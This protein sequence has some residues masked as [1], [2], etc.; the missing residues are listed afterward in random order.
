MNLKINLLENKIQSLEKQVEVL[1]KK[2]TLMN[3]MFIIHNNIKCN[4]CMKKESILI[5]TVPA[6][7][8][9]WSDHDVFLKHF[10]RYNV[11]SLENSVKKNFRLLNI[12][13]TYKSLFPLALIVIL[14]KRITSSILRRKSFKRGLAKDLEL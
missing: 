11:K 12:E 9:L 3:N 7:K 13:Y 10:R 1:S 14:I 6:M 8:I 5:L 4:N 2:N